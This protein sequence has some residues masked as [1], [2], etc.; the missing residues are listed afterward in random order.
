MT[1]SEK[2]NL[3][4][5]ILGPVL[6]LGFLSWIDWSWNAKTD[7]Q[8]AADAKFNAD[9]YATRADMGATNQR[10]DSMGR[11]LSTVSKDVALIQGAMS[12]RQGHGAEMQR[13]Q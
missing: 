10:L 4:F 1:K 8:R 3:V 2:I 11:D 7:L 9:T 12:V 13:S 6:V 5:T